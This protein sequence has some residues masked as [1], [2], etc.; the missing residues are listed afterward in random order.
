MMTTRVILLRHGRSNYNELGVFQGSCDDSV[1]TETGLAMAGKTAAYLA[2]FPIDTIYTSSLQRA[3]QTAYIVS[4]QQSEK[5]HPRASEDLQEIHLPAWQG[6]RYQFVREQHS[7]AYA[8]WKETP[9]DFAMLDPS[10]NPFYPV[11]ELFE[12]SL[13]FWQAT[14]PNHPNQTIVVVSHGGTIQALIATALGLQAAVF[15]R[16]QQSNCGLSVLNFPTGLNG[17]AQLESLNLTQHLG[18][19]LPKLKEG[20]QGTRELLWASDEGHPPI[21]IALP[22]LPGLQTHL[23]TCSTATIRSLLQRT[24]GNSFYHASCCI[25]SG[26]YCILHRPKSLKHSIIQAINWLPQM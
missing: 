22:A 25:Q 26:T 19:T 24:L 12:R 23:Q 9:Q 20:K 2:Q 3:K 6:L 17:P 10:G 1:L 13:N 8:I 11:R 5:L 16:M 7:D 15:H 21:E 4:W 18:E 14:I